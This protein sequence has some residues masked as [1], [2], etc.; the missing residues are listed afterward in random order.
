MRS[1]REIVLDFVRFCSSPNFNLVLFI[2]FFFSLSGAYDEEEAAAKAY[3]LAAL[4]YWGPGTVINFKVQFRPHSLLAS[5]A[6]LTIAARK[7]FFRKHGWLTL[8]V[9]NSW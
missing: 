6:S 9:L 4:K 5:D 7:L 2:C 1:T 8:P 3:D